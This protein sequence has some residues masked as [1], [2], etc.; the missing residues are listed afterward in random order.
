MRGAQSG[1]S[2]NPVEDHTLTPT[3]SYDSRMCSHLQRAGHVRQHGRGEGAKRAVVLRVR[4]RQGEYRTPRPR[5]L[6]AM[7]FRSDRIAHRTAPRGKFTIGSH[8]EKRLLNGRVGARR[9]HQEQQ[10]DEPRGARGA[11]LRCWLRRADALRE[12]LDGAQQVV[13][14]VEVRQVRLCQTLEH[15]GARVT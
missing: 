4:Q 1:C 10:V 14:H 9:G 11:R 15:L 3:R 13:G 7:L 2:P 6:E 8:E 5:Q 12:A